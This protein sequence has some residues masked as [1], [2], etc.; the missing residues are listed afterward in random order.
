M[1]F[2][3]KGRNNSSHIWFEIIIGLSH[4]IHKGHSYNLGLKKP[5]RNIPKCKIQFRFSILKLKTSSK[6]KSSCS[7]FFSS[8]HLTPSRSQS[9][10]LTY[11]APQKLF[12]SLYLCGF[13]TFISP[14]LFPVVLTDCDC[15]IFPQIE[16]TRPCLVDF[17]SASPS[18]EHLSPK[19]LHGSL[20]PFKSLPKCHLSAEA[21]TNHATE[22]SNRYSSFTHLPYSLQIFL[23]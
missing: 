10:Q 18:L 21:F 6:F 3:L 5:R 8:N 4:C 7:K 1:S 17:A 19:Y 22:Y 9:H 14:L 15:L 11:K 13:I 23:T 2:A 12:Q 16:Y 20:N